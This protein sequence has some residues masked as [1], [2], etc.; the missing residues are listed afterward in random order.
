MIRTLTF[1]ALLVPATATAQLQATPDPGVALARICVSEEGWGNLTGCAAIWHTAQHVRSKDCGLP[2]VTQCGTDGVET[3]LSAM[4]RM[5]KRVTGMVRALNS[6]QRW[7]QGLQ[8]PAVKPRFW[9]ECTGAPRCDGRWRD[10]RPKWEALLAYADS[11]I[12]GAKA[13][14]PCEGYVLAWGSGEDWRFMA[15]RNRGREKA[16]KRALEPLRC[17]PEVTNTFYGFPVRKAPVAAT[18]SL[19][20]KKASGRSKPCNGVC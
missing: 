7:I 8:R 19:W 5:S 16:G 9:T 12:E 10:Y 4:R 3:P 18:L 14:N 6:R 13:P 11:L 15:R 2:G 1:A 17:H 20:T